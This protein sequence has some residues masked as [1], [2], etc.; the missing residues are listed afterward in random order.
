MMYTTTLTVETACFVSV[1][2][3]MRPGSRALFLL[4]FVGLNS[5]GPIIHPLRSVL[6]DITKEHMIRRKN[7][8]IANEDDF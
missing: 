6:V 4:A 2:V 3:L 7:K 5:P 1:L 8:A